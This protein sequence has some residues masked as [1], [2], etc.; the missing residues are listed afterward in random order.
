MKQHKVLLMWFGIGFESCI[1]SAKEYSSLFHN[2][3]R[4]VLLASARNSISWN[5][6]FWCQK[7]ITSSFSHTRRSKRLRVLLISQQ[8]N[9]ISRVAH[10]STL[11]HNMFHINVTNSPPS[12][13]S[14]DTCIVQ[15]FPNPSNT[16]FSSSAISPPGQ[17]LFIPCIVFLFQIYIQQDPVSLP[18]SKISIYPSSLPWKPVSRW[19]RGFSLR[20]QCLALILSSHDTTSLLSRLQC[21]Q[22]F[23]QIRKCVQRVGNLRESIGYTLDNLK[24]SYA[25]ILQSVCLLVLMARWCSS[26][27][28]CFSCMGALRKTISQVL[29]SIERGTAF[30]CILFDCDNS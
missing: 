18:S 19:I 2:D 9:T 1:A 3:T 14:F 6:D 22:C 11:Q 26:R 4:A 5:K 8:I 27:G 24:A 21:P 30:V 20:I 29:L 12:W 28:H 13:D 16:L 25:A 23:Q 17:P 10:L 7:C 15:A